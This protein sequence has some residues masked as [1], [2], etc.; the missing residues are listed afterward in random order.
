MRTDSVVITPWECRRCNGD[1]MCAKCVREVELRKIAVRLLGCPGSPHFS[2]LLQ[3]TDRHSGDMRLEALQ[4]IDEF[5]D[6]L[7]TGE[8]VAPEILPTRVR[9]DDERRIKLAH[10]IYRALGNGARRRISTS[11]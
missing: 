7:R 10:G 2:E 9:S 4:L 5:V 1:Q 11:P 6:K 8:V 3:G